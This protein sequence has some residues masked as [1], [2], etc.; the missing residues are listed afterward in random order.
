M[1]DF[2]L[3]KNIDYNLYAINIIRKYL[4]INEKNNNALE[5]LKNQITKD[6]LI[7]LTSLLNKNEKKLSYNLLYILIGIAN[8]EDGEKL[9]SLDENICSNIASFIG[10]NK[11]DDI[12]L[13]YGMLL[14]RNI[15]INKNV[16]DI[17]NKYKII[18][19]FAEIYEKYLLNSKLME[20]ITFSI[21]NN[22]SFEIK[23]S[24]KLCNILIFL[25][26]IKI[27]ASQLR[28]NLAP[29]ILYK[30]IFKLFELLEKKKPDIYYEMVN[31]K[32]HKEMMNLYPIISSKKKLLTQKL[33]EI[34]SSNKEL[35]KEEFENFQK[36][37]NDLEYYQSICLL[38]LKILGKLMSLDDGI[39][40][41]TLL[42]A[43]IASFLYPLIQSNDIR[44]VKNAC[45]CISNI[46]AGTY[47]QIS[48]LFKNNTLYEL[49]KVSKNIYEAMELRKEKDDYYFQLKDTFREVNF[50]FTLTISNSN[51]ENCVP[52]A[53]CD[54]Y[55][56]V[57]IL[58]K[59]MKIFCN[60]DNED[61]I[62]YILYAIEKLIALNNY[63]ND[64][65]IDVM[66]KY[67]LKENLEKILM[68]K[69]WKIYKHAENI[70]DAIFGAIQ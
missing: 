20:F 14:I 52:F 28:P 43:N 68:V 17:F 10:N 15:S 57:N 47:G 39:L 27:F 67:G 53:K 7:I 70:Y 40:T 4:E 3:S 35:A 29:G 26:S 22:I 48:Y 9:F 45:F 66:E 41:Q 46:C 54:N 55:Y 49:I 64:E 42:N 32:I 6:E 37:Q 69:K 59:G 1:N 16:C 19:F 51:F 13:H 18:E 21:C 5:L 63:F 25:P 8:I 31:C 61:L 56:A 38:I 30:Y 23:K 44:T 34:I 11:N 36:D 24:D 33:N 65:I 12:F 50:V 58:M 2:F 62:D 60:L